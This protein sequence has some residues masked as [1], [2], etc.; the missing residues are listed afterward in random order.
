MRLI[1]GLLGAIGSKSGV[2]TGA[3]NGPDWKR[4]KPVETATIVYPMTAAAVRLQHKEN[5][6]YETSF[7]RN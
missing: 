2:L 3:L 6:A 5:F 1:A 4:H 7:R